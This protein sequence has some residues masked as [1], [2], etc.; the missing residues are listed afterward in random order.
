MI[1]VLGRLPV[2]ELWL[3]NGFLVLVDSN[4]GIEQ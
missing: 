2:I 4:V 1:L 3:N